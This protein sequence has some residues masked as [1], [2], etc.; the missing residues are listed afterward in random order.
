MD[1]IVEELMEAAMDNW[2]ACSL[3]GARVE[4]ERVLEYAANVYPKLVKT[5]A[6]ITC[7]I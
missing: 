1:E 3:C 4:V 6:H 2:M 5:Q 7:N